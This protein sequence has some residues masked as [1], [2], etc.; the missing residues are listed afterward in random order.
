MIGKDILVTCSQ[1]SQK[2]TATEGGF[3]YAH[4]SPDLRWPAHLW[5]ACDGSNKEV[6]A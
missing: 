6:K 3:V 5:P 1:C 2:V 4:K